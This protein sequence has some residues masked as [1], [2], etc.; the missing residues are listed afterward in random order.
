MTNF[1]LTHLMNWESHYYIGNLQV[2]RHIII[3]ETVIFYS[4]IDMFCLYMV[5]R[6]IKIIPFKIIQFLLLVTSAV[7][8]HNHFFNL[9]DCL[10]CKIRANRSSTSNSLSISEDRVL[11]FRLVASQHLGSS[12][13]SVV[14]LWNHKKVAILIFV[15]FLLFMALF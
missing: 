5:I 12:L 7:F 13:T 3:T 8:R 6:Y 4:N 2:I 15:I 9:W 1:Y 11:D 14:T 10:Y